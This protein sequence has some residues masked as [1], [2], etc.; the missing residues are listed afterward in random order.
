[1]VLL[2]TCNYN[3]NAV[4]SPASYTTHCIK[5]SLPKRYPS[6]LDPGVIENCIYAEAAL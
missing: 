4:C 5:E 1:M 2:S 3:T 6:V